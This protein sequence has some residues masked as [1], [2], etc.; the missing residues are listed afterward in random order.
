MSCED[1][2]ACGDCTNDC[3]P[4]NQVVDIE[5]YKTELATLRQ[6]TKE[7]E[8]KISNLATSDNSLDAA[9]KPTSTLRSAKWL[10]QEGNKAMSALYMD[11]YLNFGLTR[12]ELMSNKPIIGIANSGSDLAPCNRYHLTL[13]KRVREGIRTAGAIAIEFPTHP[14]QESS[15]RPTAT[16]DR[17]LSYL[18]LVEMLYAYPFDG[19]VLMTG[20]DK[21]T[22]A[23]L[24]AAATMNIPAIVLN[25]GPML[26]GYMGKNLIGSGTVLWKARELHAAGEID[27]EQLVEMVTRGTPSAGHCNTMGTASTMNALAEALGMALPGSAGIPAPYRERQQ[28]AYKTGT[29]I[30]EMVLADRK[31][32]DIMTREAF[33]NAIVVNTAIGGSTNA[34]IHLNAIAKHMGVPLSNDDWDKIG[35]EH[36]LLANVQPAG[37]FLCEEYYRAGGLPAI[38][39]E[40]LEAKALPHPDA[41]TVTGRSLSHHARAE[42]LSWDR[43][44]ILPYNKPMKHN[45]GFLHMKGNLFASAIMK[46]S[47]ISPAFQAEFL[48]NPDDLNAFE[49]KAIVFDGPEDYNARIED[50]ATGVDARTILVMRGAGP[51]GYPGAA[52]VVNMHAPGRL[53]K[54]GVQSLPCIGDGR[55]SGTSGSPSI[56]NASPEAAAG[57]NLAVLRDGDFLR[58]DLNKRVVNILVSE[59]ELKKR[60]DELEKDGGFKIPESHTPWQEMFRRETGQL[61]EGMVIESAVKYQRIAQKYPTPRDNH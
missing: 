21:T 47:V 25:V 60:W 51:L 34:P 33:E 30:V 17:N 3:A 54:Q 61:S 19:V 26:N 28:V 7:L 11:R 37:E 49:C 22:P 12:E 52:E 31:P 46:T 18:T 44:V 43:R 27:D 56:L 39:A 8:E 4:S 35:Y 53:L 15:R 24:M 55:Q 57:G 23:C 5:D 38:I 16:L 50:P 45:A 1:K 59:E 41:L 58:V 42:G 14:I 9:T 48:S 40:L 6:R 2:T 13:A 10:N 32:S 20:C 29:Q 36:P